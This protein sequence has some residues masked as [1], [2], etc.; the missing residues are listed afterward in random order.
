MIARIAGKRVR[1][2]H[3]S[4]P[5]GVRGRRS[6]NRLIWEK[7]G[8]APSKALVDGLAPTYRWIESRVRLAG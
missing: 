1:L 5:T 4:G 7:L 2:R 6:D 3:V 8:W